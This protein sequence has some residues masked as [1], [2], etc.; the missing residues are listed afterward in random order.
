MMPGVSSRTVETATGH[1]I[2][3]HE[4]GSGQPVVFIHGSGPGASGISNF[5]HNLGALAAAGHYVVAPDLIGYGGSSMPIG[6]DYTLDFFVDTLMGALAAIGIERCSL[7]G[8]S[9]GGAIAL[10]I[11]LDRPRFVDKL[12][13]MAPGG[14]E[15]RETYFAMP[16]IQKMVGAFAAEGFDEARMRL[17]LGNLVVDPK[18]ITDELVAERLSV[19][20]VQPKEVLS[21]MRVPDLSPRLGELAMPILGFWGTED[22]FCPASGAEKFLK[23][24][25]DARFVLYG[26]CGHWVMVERAREFNRYVL[27][28]LAA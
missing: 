9:L 12:I 4:G 6:Q 20:R 26:R 19:A 8:N 18:V 16:G 24:C 7:V 3:L 27:D 23:S 17:L 21:T 14:I 13:L 25:P 5:R 28:F 2:H 22:G 15:T 11:A 10:K 1:R